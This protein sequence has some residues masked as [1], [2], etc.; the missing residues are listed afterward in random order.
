[1]K[2]L[3]AVI[4]CLIITAGLFAG[5][6]GN[7]KTLMFDY[8][9]LSK[10]VEVPEYKGIEFSKSEAEFTKI[11]ADKM[12]SDMVGA[13]LTSEVEIA[14]G[15]VQDGDKVH[16]TYVGKHNGEAF[17][18]GSTD[19][20]GTDLV[21]GSNTYIDGFESGLIGA[22]P[23]S[24]VVLN[25]TFPDPY[26]NNEKL[27]G[28][29]VEFTVNIQKITRT[30]YPEVDDEVAKKLGYNSAS[31]YNKFVYETA[32]KNY[33]Y[34]KIVKGAK[35]LKVPETELNYYVDIDLKYYENYAKQV[36]YTF[37]QFLQAYGMDEAAF[38]K[39][40]SDMH[41]EN[42]PNYITIYYIAKA[43]NLTVGEKELNAEYEKLAKE[44]SMKVADVKKEIEVK[45][46]E[47]SVLYNRVLD[48]VFE[49]AK[50]KD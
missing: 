47:Y 25:L 28:E 46:V 20:A 43:E 1:M 19:A 37:E 50:I 18:G 3:V 4:L 5:C 41:K 34:D 42:M 26:P 45:Q 36:G 29:K 10:Y 2:R 40:I 6:K 22:A 8:K 33:A 15:T 32:A 44:Y 35:L 21:I 48:F 14:S 27:S 49:N 23:G 38:K 12:A 30:E 9:D 7:G 24:T 17:S 39:Q 31:E 16:I 11:I 13:K